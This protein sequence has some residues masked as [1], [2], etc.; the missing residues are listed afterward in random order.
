MIVV[1]NVL[2][3]VYFSVLDSYFD[4]AAIRQNREGRL[5]CEN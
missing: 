3:E 1:G 4:T 5:N 2:D